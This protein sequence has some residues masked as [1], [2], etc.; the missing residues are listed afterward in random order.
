ADGNLVERQSQFIGDDLRG[1]GKKPLPHLDAA[2]EQDSGA[3]SVQAHARRGRRRRGRTL[4]RDSKSLAAPQRWARREHRLLRFSF[5]T[6]SLRPPSQTV[7]D[8]DR[9]KILAGDE[10]IAFMYEMIQPQ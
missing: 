9:D 1:R 8:P 10:D 7:R 6:D 3:I 4:D 5:P 2:G